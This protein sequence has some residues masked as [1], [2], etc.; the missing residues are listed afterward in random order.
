MVGIIVGDSRDGID[1]LGAQRSEFGLHAFA[2]PGQRVGDVQGVA[3]KFALGVALYVA[4][5]G[6]VGEVEHRL[7]DFQAHRRIDLVNV[8]QIGFGAD[9]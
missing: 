6:H 5:L 4:Q 1:C 9:E 8:E 2:A 3:A 7:G